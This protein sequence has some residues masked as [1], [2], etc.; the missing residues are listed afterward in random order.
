[1]LKNLALVAGVLMALAIFPQAYKIFKDKAARD[2]SALTFIILTAGSFIWLLYGLDDHD[3]PI[4]ASY[5]IRFVAA[6][7]V[8][9]L[10]VYY[11]RRGRH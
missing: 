2:V 8:L 3:T 11:A 6:G 4:V 10:I 1:M 9:G 5:A 7:L